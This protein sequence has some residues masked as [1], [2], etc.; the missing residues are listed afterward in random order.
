MALT[1]KKK[2][3]GFPYDFTLPYK[4]VAVIQQ[5]HTVHLVI[6]LLHVADT[7]QAADMEAK[8]TVS[9]SS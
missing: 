7:K 1:A 4:K 5:R 9:P 2:W 8:Y 3:T 6:D